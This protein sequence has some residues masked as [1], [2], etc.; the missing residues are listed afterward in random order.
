MRYGRPRGIPGVSL[1]ALGGVAVA[2][3]AW[4]DGGVTCGS[5]IS[6]ASRPQ[7]PPATLTTRRTQGVS[8]PGAQRWSRLGGP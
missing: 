1:V 6:R 8:W 2:P 3:G 7:P 5:P 4:C